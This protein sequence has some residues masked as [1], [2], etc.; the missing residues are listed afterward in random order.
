M[1]PSYEQYKYNCPAM[2]Y[3]VW[4]LSKRE[5]SHSVCLHLSI[6]VPGKTNLSPQLPPLAWPDSPISCKQRPFLAK[7]TLLLFNNL[8]PGSP[9]YGKSSRM[10]LVTTDA[11]LKP[12]TQEV[13]YEAEVPRQADT[14]DPAQMITA[15]RLHSF[16]ETHTHTHQHLANSTQLSWGCK[17][18]QAQ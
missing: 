13:T 9:Y 2:E 10:E 17:G 6:P 14:G 12:S 18:H 7:W 16:Q 5:V 15:L 1:Y 4:P 3:N 11:D 8:S